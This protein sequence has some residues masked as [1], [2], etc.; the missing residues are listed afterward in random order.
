MKLI[1]SV[2]T[3]LFLFAACSSHEEQVV[4]VVPPKANNMYIEIS[5]EF[6]NYDTS[7]SNLEVTRVPTFDE[8]RLVA[9]PDSFISSVTLTIPD[10][11]ANTSISFRENPNADI[12]LII[13][14]LIYENAEGTLN[15][16]D[17]DVSGTYSK[18]DHV[19]SFSGRVYS[20]VN[21][22]NFYTVDTASVMY[23]Q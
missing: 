23:R 4:E 14:G 10:S 1:L 5:D 3:G 22:A 16:Q 12:E 21:P 8:L 9:S 6:G 2:I 11:L 15:I 18:G 13:D 17:N 20:R 7:F 19:A